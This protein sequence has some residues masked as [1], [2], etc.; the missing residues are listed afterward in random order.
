MSRHDDKAEKDYTNDTPGGVMKYACITAAAAFLG[1]ILAANYVTTEYGMVPVGFGL[2]ATAGT[3]FA[4]LTF[5]L[6]D[7]LQRAVGPW[8]VLGLIVAGAALSY[9]VSDPFIALA[10][11]VAF[12]V[13]E[14]AD[15]LVWTPLEEKGYIRAAVA[16]NTVGAVL[17]TFLF[18]WIAGFPI[19]GAW[20]GQVVGKV[21]IT[22]GVVLV[23]VGVRGA[24]SRESVRV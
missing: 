1:C 23:V 15:L 16:S 9:L 5:V 6:R 12:G 17:D 14:F 24:V 8:P 11:A 3:Y 22:L 7:S 4:G 2:M 13:S 20:Q 19:A 21:S 10:S 18:L